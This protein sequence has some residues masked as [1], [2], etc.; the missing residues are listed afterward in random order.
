MRYISSR[1]LA[2]EAAVRVLATW[3]RSWKWSP[4]SP[5]AARALAHFACHVIAERPAL[6]AGEHE[7]VRP[8]LA[9]AAAVSPELGSERLGKRDLAAPGV[10]LRRTDH[11]RAVTE[12]LTLLGD[13]NRPVQQVDPAAREAE[14]LAA[15]EARE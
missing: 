6:V 8:G 11:Q 5:T 10:G 14:Q 3:R 1:V 15:A 12:L 2:P 4:R 9:E 13:D 7:P